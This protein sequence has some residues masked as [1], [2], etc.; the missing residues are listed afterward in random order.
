MAAA[1]D[2]ARPAYDQLTGV[3]VTWRPDCHALPTETEHLDYCDGVS[4]PVVE[5]SGIAGSNR[6]ETPL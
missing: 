1:I 3:T 6:L 4:H 5:G 2:R